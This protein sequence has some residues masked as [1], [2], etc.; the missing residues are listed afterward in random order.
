M[1][2]ALG[3]AST[4]APH[5]PT[6]A[7]AYE[8][9]LQKIALPARLVAGNER[10]SRSD[11][12]LGPYVCARRLHPADPAAESE[13]DAAFPGCSLSAW[14]LDTCGTLPGDP[15]PFTL[16]LVE[17]RTRECLARTDLRVGDEHLRLL[18]VIA[19]DHAQ[20]ESLVLAF[21]VYRIDTASLEPLLHC[22]VKHATPRALSVMP[23]GFEQASGWRNLFLDLHRQVIECWCT[24]ERFLDGAAMHQYEQ[25]TTIGYMMTG[26]SVE[27]PELLE[28][29]LEK[30]PEP[31]WML[32]LVPAG[33]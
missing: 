31:V 27:H 24:P 15:R 28:T 22:T 26:G 7:V 29:P 1:L 21:T 25:G 32:T 4:P 18:V 19:F 17:G 20:D 14:E 30:W 13:L 5:P 11:P 16:A 10:E 33:P 3:C 12:D 8:A 2:F 9:R 23:C 6:Q